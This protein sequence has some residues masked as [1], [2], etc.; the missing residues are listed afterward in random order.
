MRS[1]TKDNDLHRL[2]EGGRHYKLAKKQILQT[3]E[4]RQVVN[5]VID[6]YIKRYIILNDGSIGVQITY[7]PGDVFPLTIVFKTLFDQSLY[8]GPEVFYY[9][10]LTDSEI[11]SVSASD[12]C[13]EVKKS[14]KLYQ[15][16]LQ[17]AGVH[18]ESCVHSLENVALKNSQKRVAHQLNF[19]AKNFGHKTSRG[20]VINAP[21]THQD[22]ADILSLTRE[23][24]STAMVQLRKKNLILTEKEII[25]PD[26]AK[27][28]EEAYS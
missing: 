26:L 12:L 11:A 2:L 7:G 22:L 6:G 24:I 17:E 3:T 27:L 1:L 15:D 14:P 8:T 4:D 10:T 9:E 28:E 20:T 25:V 18:L 5:L 16:L 19:F 23:T 21:F 13:E